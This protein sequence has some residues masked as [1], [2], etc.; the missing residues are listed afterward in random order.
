[1]LDHGLVCGDGGSCELWV[2]IWASLHVTTDETKL[3]TM[4]ARW[5]FF[6]VMRLGCMVRVFVV[7]LWHVRDKIVVG[8]AVVWDQGASSVITGDLDLIGVDLIVVDDVRLT[9]VLDHG[10]ICG[11]SGSC[12][13]WVGTV[14]SESIASGDVELDSM[15]ALRLVMM[16]RVLVVMR[17]GS[18]VRVFVVSLWHVRDKI[19]VGVAVVWD[20]GASSVITGD[21]DLIGVDLIVV[22]DV[23]LTV[24]LDHGLVCGDGGSCELWV[25]T[26]SSESIATGDVELDS[27]SALG[28]V[29]V[30]MVVV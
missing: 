11:D 12:E 25:G 29:V 27:M 26:V 4:G 18:M 6:V 15:S 17:L 5:S 10:L 3:N 14:S 28:F 2:G 19:V 30:I 7:S 13:L 21:L 16:V 9:V 23:G 22:D 20:Q 1:M 8:V 24:V